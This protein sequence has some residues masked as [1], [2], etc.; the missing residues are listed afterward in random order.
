MLM[1]GKHTGHSSIRGNKSITQVGVAPLWASDITLAEAVRKNTD[2]V[3]GMSGRWH[4]GGELTNQTPY[5]RGFDYHFGKLSA[6]FPNK[7]G[8]M[9]DLN[10]DVNGK[11][12]TY[13]E[14]AAKNS[15]A[16]FEN[17]KLYNLTPEE[18]AR[19]PINMDR[20]VTDKAKAFIDREKSRPFF[21]YVAYSLVHSPMEYHDATPVEAND[22]PEAERAFASMLMSLDKYVGEILDLVDRLGLG[23][24]TL[25]VFSSD[26]GAHN[27][28]GHD[29]TFFNS[30]GEFRGFK[31]DVYDGGMH[32]PLFCRWTGT[33]KPGSHSDLLSA[34]W[35]VMP[36]V[37]DL[38]G[39]P[40]PESTDGLSMAPTL[41]GKPQTERHEFLY[42]EFNERSDRKRP[43]AEYKQAVVFDKWKVINYLDAQRVELYALAALEGKDKLGREWV[44]EQNDLAAKYPE[45]V[46]RG[47]L[48][49]AAS[50][51]QNPIFPMTRHERGKEVNGK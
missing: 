24:K 22:W 7:Q 45:L 44:V 37:C 42:W 47:L 10:W 33:I 30:T 31:R 46:K 27:E 8:V 13:S 32:T 25:V 3:T 1:T 9:I 48:Y 12:L 51:I 39:A 34:F 41:L 2:Y 40:I 14:Y 28:G 11:H 36:T 38:A 16:M 18:Q 50:H 5:H 29:H 17:G 6:D 35:D 4:L 20:L 26:N 19:R 43:G 15:E 23:Q 49:M 21:L